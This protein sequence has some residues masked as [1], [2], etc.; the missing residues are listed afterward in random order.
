MR[1]QELYRDA[2]S[3]LRLAEASNSCI[4]VT[5]SLPTSCSQ[6]SCRFGFEKQ[7][8]TSKVF[9]DKGIRY[10]G[11]NDTFRSFLADGEATFN[12]SVSLHGFLERIR[13]VADERLDD[14]ERPEREATPASS[15][16]S[17]Q[18]APLNLREIA[19]AGDIA[20][21]PVRPI[22]F[23]AEGFLADLK[24]EVIG[25]DAA[26]TSL[27]RAINAQVRKRK[28]ERPLNVLLAGKSG[29]GKTKTAEELA[30]ILGRR[31]GTRWGYIRVDM[32]QLNAEHTVSRLIGAPPGYAGYGDAPLFEPLLH[33]QRQVIL[34]DEMEKAHPKVMQM[35]MNAMAN[36]RLEASSAMQS[37][38]AVFDFQK[39]IL[40]FTTNFPLRVDNGLSDQEVTRRCRQQLCRS[41][42]SAAPM[43]R[44]IANRFTSIILYSPLGEREKMDIFV[45]TIIRLGRQY[46]LEVRR[47]SK[48]LLQGFADLV[49]LD[50]G[51]RD[52]EYDMETY[53]GNAFANFADLGA[54]TDIKLSGAP[55]SVQI[56]FFGR[57][58]ETK[59]NKENKPL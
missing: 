55:E 37:E 19:G 25:Q 47:I 48:D 3:R 21:R 24:A 5:V 35:L 40:V 58:A 17:H 30:P 7:G 52:L 6:E 54:G 44:E 26:L 9:V 39:C 27:T 53:L 2:E 32:N 4:V 15:E 16:A 20:Q 11:S 31:T 10:S 8:T 45:L 38:A 56:D 13:M 43:L 18:A 1:I 50:N 33:N 14:E 49:E 51:V 42:T 36:G 28:P 23:D 46:G 22:R 12:D 34:F 29:V 41:R 59:N 57:N